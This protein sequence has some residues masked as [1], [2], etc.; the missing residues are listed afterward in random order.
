MLES[1]I[2]RCI[3]DHLDRHS[4][5]NDSQHGFTTGRSCLTNLLSFYKKVIEEKD[6]DENYDVVYLD[7]SKGFH[8][9]QHQR[10]LKKEEA[11]GIDSRVLKW[12]GEWLNC[13]KQ[14]TIQRK[15][16]DWGCVTSGVP[17]GSVLGPLLFIIYNNELDVG[18]SSG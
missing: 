15:K 17:Q 16:S 13:G 11:H 4:L 5:I 2:A 6:Q 7:F 9:V 8:M 18:I 12:I 1:I 10:L 3:W 14:S